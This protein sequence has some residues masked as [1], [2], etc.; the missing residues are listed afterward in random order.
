MQG[1]TQSF[2]N[3]SEAV[4][5][6]GI[7]QHVDDTMSQCTICLLELEVNEV[8]AQLNPR[9]GHACLHHLT[10]WRARNFF[11]KCVSTH[12]GVQHG[13]DLLHPGDVSTYQST[14]ADTFVIANKVHCFIHQQY[15]FTFFLPVPPFYQPLLFYAV[16]ISFSE[17]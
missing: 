6:V 9:C 15:L 4:E 2:S 17:Q 1:C 3:V 11:L 10:Q 13:Y 12:C 7:S 8:E 16:T 14:V 5:T